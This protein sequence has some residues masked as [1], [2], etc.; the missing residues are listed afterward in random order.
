[1]F[2]HNFRMTAST[3]SGERTTNRTYEASGHV[4]INEVIPAPS[5][6]LQLTCAIDVSAVKS[7]LILSD[8]DITIKTNSSSEPTNTLALKAG[9]AYE[10][11]TDSYD[12][13]KLTG[14][15]TAI[16]VTHAGETAA[17]LTI[18]VVQDVTP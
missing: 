5:T 3:P 15:V 2:Q 9:V 13:L 16:F 14:D 7:L 18:D 4:G 17:N 1:M 12:T 6:N 11:T 10:W 8:Q